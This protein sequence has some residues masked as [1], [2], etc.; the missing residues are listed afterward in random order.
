MHILNIGSINID[1]VYT[2]DHF[3]RPGETLAS[4]HYDIFAGGKGFNQSIALARAG[5][6]VRHAGMVGADGT[7]L[8]ER[9]QRQGVDITAIAVTTSATGHAVI[10]VVPTGEN[11]IVLYGGANFAITD[12]HIAQSVSSCSPGDYLLIQNE[13]S[14]VAT[15]IRIGRQQGLRVVY[16]PAPMTPAVRGY[17]LNDV[18]IFILNETEAEGLTGETTP[19]GIRRAMSQQFPRAATVLTLGRQGA[20]Y[21]D[22]L[23]LL[24]QPAAAV[25][26]VDTTAAGDTFIGYFL[27]ELM[28]S[29]DQGKALALGCRAAA[30]CVTRVGASDSIPDRIEVDAANQQIHLIAGRPGSG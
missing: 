15:A 3:V 5:V 8:L 6:S 10:Q 28:R 26:A 19:D 14:S 12:A 22:A 29:G 30:I 13:T 1:H 27:A 2:V 7:W 18:D 25:T 16:N 24:R 23:R 17:P 20:L 4:V 21:F 9:L 11:A